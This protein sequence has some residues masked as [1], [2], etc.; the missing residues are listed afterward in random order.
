MIQTA[1]AAQKSDRYLDSFERLSPAL[2]SLHGDWLM[3]LRQNALARFAE[4]G[5]P[6]L[7]DEEWPYTNLAPLLRLPFLPAEQAPVETPSID[8]LEEL[9]FSTLKGP[10]L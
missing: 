7:Q 8:D 9:P 6:T 1:P 10:R 3:P 4:T 2:E 5:L